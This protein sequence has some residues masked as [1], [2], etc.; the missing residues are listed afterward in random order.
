MNTVHEFP[1]VVRRLEVAWQDQGWIPVL[2]RRTARGRRVRELVPTGHWRLS[3]NL[4]GSG[5]GATCSARRLQVG[6]TLIEMLVVI[7]IIGILAGILLPTLAGVRKRAKV[8]TAKTEMKNLQGAI[9]QYENSYSRYPVSPATEAVVKA[10]KGDATLTNNSEVVVILLDQNREPN[11][12]SVRN[13]RH[14][15]MLQVK[16]AGSTGSPGVGPDYVY[17]DPWSSPFVITMDMNGDNKCVDPTDPTGKNLI[18]QDV[19]V[20]S[21]GPD[22]RPGTKDDL[23]SWK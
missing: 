11:L 9:A 19:L 7:A 15:V 8:A 22:V 21:F 1:G 2:R 12:E 18:S 6:F 14:E 23:C 5:R 3:S 4:C 10:S 20:R 16:L 13:P 17:R